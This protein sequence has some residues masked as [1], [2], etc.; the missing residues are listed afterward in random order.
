MPVGGALHG[1]SA[2]PPPLRYRSLMAHTVIVGSGNIGGTLTRRLRAAGRDV[3]VAVR[4]LHSERAVDLATRTGARLATTGD[5]LS[6]AEV[7]VLAVP[8]G[9]VADL[10]R[11]TAT[12]LDGLVVIDATN[13]IAGGGPFNAHEALTAAAPG[14]IYARA[15]NTLGWEN[16][17]D[18]EIGGMTA[19]LFW[20]GDDRATTAVEALIGDVGLHP[21][22]VGG[23]E[24]LEVVDNLTRMW[25]ALALTNGMGRH[26][27]FKVLHE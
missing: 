2:A 22:R 13:N 27:A 18:P 24:Q 8:G 5:A 25:F 19:D 11:E 3:V 15:F 10:V 1:T 9:A 21:I 17:A 14:V 7:V 16:F 4:D 26:L 6:G 12:A 23:V 20:C